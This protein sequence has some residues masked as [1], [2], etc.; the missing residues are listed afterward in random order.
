MPAVA[1]L[2]RSSPQSVDGDQQ[3]IQA[4]VDV[5]S[6]QSP[7]AVTAGVTGGSEWSGGSNAWFDAGQQLGSDIG[8]EHGQ[9]GAE[10]TAAAHPTAT[11][12]TMARSESCSSDAGGAGDLD[13]SLGNAMR[14]VFMSSVGEVQRYARIFPE[15]HEKA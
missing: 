12:H 10:S 9:E 11:V 5:L 6:L 7:K 1:Q 4:R 2:L 13:A 3:T 14:E 8:R 15:I